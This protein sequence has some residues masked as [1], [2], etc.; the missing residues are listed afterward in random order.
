MCGVR[1]KTSL[2]E[3]ISTKIDQGDTYLYTKVHVANKTITTERL[4][5]L[6]H[7]F[8]ERNGGHGN[9]EKN[10]NSRA[11]CGYGKK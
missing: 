4:D 5:G 2:N 11:A 8:M 6:E 3:V 1:P 10:Y 9:N 7:E